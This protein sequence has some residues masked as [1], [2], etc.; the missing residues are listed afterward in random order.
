MS[1]EYPEAWIPET[2]HVTLAVLGKFAEEL[3]EAI[4]IVTRCVIQGSGEADPETGTPNLV[5]L[6]EE[7]A[8][9]M[10]TTN[11]AIEYFALNRDEIHARVQRK[12]LHLRTWHDLIRREK[13]SA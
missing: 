4:K 7:I 3:S 2:D 6:R 9:V 12:E 11:V 8:D 5:A 10:A 13:E 1:R